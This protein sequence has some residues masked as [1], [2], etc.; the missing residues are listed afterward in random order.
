[1]TSPGG[2]S[3]CLLVV[4]KMSGTYN[5]VAFSLEG[6]PLAVLC[7]GLDLEFHP[8]LVLDHLVPFAFLAPAISS[9]L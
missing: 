5:L 4:H 8:L 2:M 1:M 6:Y 3:G 9:P 7:S